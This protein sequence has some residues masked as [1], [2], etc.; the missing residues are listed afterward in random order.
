MKNFLKLM[1]LPVLLFVAGCSS[2]SD[3]TPGGGNTDDFDR[4][5]MLKNWSDN[6]IIPSFENFSVEVQTLEEVSLKFTQDPTEANLADLRSAYKEAYVQFQTVSPFD[7]GKAETLNYRNNLNTYPVDAAAM[8]EKI[9]AGEFNLELPSAMD[10]QGFPALAYLLYGLGDT[11][12]EIIA[13]Y[14]SNANAATYKNYLNAVSVRV[15]SLTSE[16]LSDWKNNFRDQFVNN[17][18]SSSTGSV[19]RLTNDYIMY[20]E[21]F[22]RAGKIGIPAGVFSGNP[23]PENVEAYYSAE[24]SKQLYL[25]SVE[26]VHNFFVGNYFGE[27]RKGLSYVD[28]LRYLNTIKNGDPLGGLING[29]F[30][31]IRMQADELDANL[32]SQIESDNTKMLAAYDELQKNVVL[33]KVDMVQ[34]LSV[35]ID[36]VDSDGD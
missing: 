12:A 3:D 13:H 23:V 19:D 29:Q 15:N 18:S 2:N 21:K 9:Q 1:F 4:G 31:N 28:Y 17:T 33:L 20:Y 22:L 7:I 30:N 32:V 34:A 24:L 16:V 6:I 25:K 11:D 8:E 5:A 10:E 27:D 14:T 35:S 36:Y 26:T